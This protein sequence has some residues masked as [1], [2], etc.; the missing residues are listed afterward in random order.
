MASFIALNDSNESPAAPI[1][2]SARTCQPVENNYSRRMAKKSDA[3]STA[4]TSSRKA[5]GKDSFLG[6]ANAGR[7]KSSP[8]LDTQHS[9]VTPG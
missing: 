9:L 3:A 8:L 1:L 7:M 4:K 2:S 6:E 5:A